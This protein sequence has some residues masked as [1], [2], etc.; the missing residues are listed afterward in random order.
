MQLTKFSDYALR[1][2]IFAASS[3]ERLVTIEEIGAAFDISRA[4]VKKVVNHLSRAG[5]LEAVRGRKGGLRLALEPGEI[6]LGQVL[7]L[8]ETGF[9]CFDCR[10]CAIASDCRLIGVGM[11][12]TAAFLAVFDRQTLADILVPASALGLEV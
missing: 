7:R 9:D 4:H 3:G 6:N 5:Y 11:A 8:T 12:A 2:M 1:V 10:G